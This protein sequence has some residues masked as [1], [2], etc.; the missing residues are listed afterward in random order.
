MTTT[1]TCPNCGKPTDTQFR[2]FCS[3]RCAEVD[4]GRW[5]KEVYRVPGEAIDPAFNDNEPDPA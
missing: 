2:P 3:K 4:L 5:L 1:G